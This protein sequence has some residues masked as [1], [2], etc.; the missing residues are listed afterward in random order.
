MESPT[1][2]RIVEYVLNDGDADTVNDM[3]QNKPG[4]M[5][6]LAARGDLVPAMVVWPHGGGSFNG[7]AFL[8]GNDTLWLTSVQHGADG[9]PGTWNWTARAVH[10]SGLVAPA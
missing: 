7:Q 1:I 9:E 10:E 2:G 4:R 8:D 3:R 5:G 6:N